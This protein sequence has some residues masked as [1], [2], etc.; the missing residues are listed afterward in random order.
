MSIFDGLLGNL[1]ELAG[2][3]GLPTD[4]VQTMVQAVQ[5]KM[6]SGGDMMASLT[7]VAQEHGISMDS[8]QG[9]LGNVGSGAQG[10]L[11]SIGDGAQDM[12]GKVTGALD[13]DG[14]GNPLNDLG[15]L[16]KGLFGKN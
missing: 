9:M 8:L 12:L 14:D 1:D 13:K 10:M 11:G 4:Q 2:K 5:E 3:L 15:D 6:A 16:A 7:Q